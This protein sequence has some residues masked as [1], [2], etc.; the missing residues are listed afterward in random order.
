MKYILLSVLAVMVMFGIS[1]LVTDA[2]MENSP[3]FNFK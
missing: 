1:F 3:F 2:R